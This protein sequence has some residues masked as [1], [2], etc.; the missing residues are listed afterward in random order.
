MIRQ[1]WIICREDILSPLPWQS[2]PPLAT[3]SWARMAE[4][5]ACAIIISAVSGGS[6][7]VGLF[8]CQQD[9]PKCVYC[10]IC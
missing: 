10:S 1:A 6:C 3:L 5:G 8:N 4:R 2:P 7:H 9:R